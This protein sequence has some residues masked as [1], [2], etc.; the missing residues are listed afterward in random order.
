MF[1][2]LLLGTYECIIEEIGASKL[3]IKFTRLEPPIPLF[4]HIAINVNL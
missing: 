2:T 3:E 1:Q 4:Y